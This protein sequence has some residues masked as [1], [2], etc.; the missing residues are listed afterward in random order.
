[1]VNIILFYLQIYNYID[2][3]N[4]YKNNILLLQY[5]INRLTTLSIIPTIIDI[6]KG[7]FY[8]V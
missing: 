5:G 2:Y 1:M 3:K 4:M 8:H 6:K 7:L